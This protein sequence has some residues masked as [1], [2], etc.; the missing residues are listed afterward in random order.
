MNRVR[1]TTGLIF[2]LALILALGILGSAPGPRSPPAPDRLLEGGGEPDGLHDQEE[3]GYVPV[4]GGRIYYQEGGEGPPVVLIHGGYL[5][6]RMWD[7]QIEA[8]KANYRVVRYDV[9]SHGRSHAL[10]GP[11]SDPDDLSVL[12]D[13]LKIPRAHLV[14]LSLG[15]QIAL[16]FAILNPDRV[17]SLLLAGPGLGGFPAGSPQVVRY[18]EE[19]TDALNREAFPETIEIFTRYWCDGPF[20]SPAEVDP[21][22]R[23]KVL[24]ML[25][26]SRERWGRSRLAR[27][28]DPPAMDRVSEIDAPTLILFGTLDMPDLKEV[29]D[30]LEATIPNARRV[31][32]PGVAHMVNLEAPERFNEVL[33]EFLGAH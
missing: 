6:H 9:R 20:R 18:M 5:D 13:T 21:D 7:G 22:V 17:E 10:E 26:G 11:F 8:L 4:E 1:R 32:I 31:D 29:V 30:Y 12:L 23:G 15:G 33:L 19:I 2:S 28:L 24:E 27:Q 3:E 14:G 25:S 16:D